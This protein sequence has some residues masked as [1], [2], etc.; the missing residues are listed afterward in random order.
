MKMMCSKWQGRN[1]EEGMKCLIWRGYW[2]I[3][4]LEAWIS[5]FFRE[6]EKLWI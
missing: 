1:S 2:I 5:I 6:R 4:T 3:K